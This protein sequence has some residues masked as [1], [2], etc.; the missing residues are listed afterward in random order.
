MNPPL[1]R[2][3]SNPQPRDPR[4]CETEAELVQAFAEMSVET[5][6]YDRHIE[7]LRGGVPQVLSELRRSIA[8]S[9]LDRLRRLGSA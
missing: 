2:L 6:E 8:R 1:A 9:Q 4:D 5:E 3:L 7:S